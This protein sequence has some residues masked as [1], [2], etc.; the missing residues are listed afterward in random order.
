MKKENMEEIDII[1]CV[2][3]NNK[4]FQNIKKITMRKKKTLKI[5]N[6]PFDCIKHGTR[7]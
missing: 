7:G 3:K 6:L 4:N 2:K 5:D 1:I